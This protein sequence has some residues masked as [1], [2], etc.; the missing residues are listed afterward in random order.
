MAQ[1]SDVQKKYVVAVSGGV[2]SVA[3]LHALVHHQ[4]HELGC[5]RPNAHY[6]LI[7][8]HVDHGMRANSAADA[9]FVQRLAKQY[10]LPFELYQTKLGE[11]ASEAQAREVRYSYL[12]QC[13][14][15]YGTSTI[16]TAHHQ[17][18][19]IE[20]AVINLIR[21]SGWRGLASLNET[22]RI[23]Q[24]KNK[25]CTILRPLLNTA[26][27]ELIEYA[28]QHKLEWHE[29]TTNQNQDYLRNYIRHTLI[30]HAQKRD[31]SFNKK[32]L[33]SIKGV[34][35]VRAEIDTELEYILAKLKRSEK[36]Y[37]VLRY[38]LVMWPPEVASEFI[39]TMLRKLD[40][41]WHPDQKSIAAVL[42]FCKTGLPGKKHIVSGNIQVLAAKRELVFVLRPIGSDMVK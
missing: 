20:T 30:P 13:C 18:D 5:Q 8:A 2:D 16:L 11:D 25:Q 22:T 40:P 35:N 19:V 4:M 7:V 34:K 9:H 6:Q 23:I 27:V 14:K 12:R 24:P 1:M 41:S 17:D 3:L 10:G 37:A 33:Q 32:I 38:Q 42:H 29:D 39:Y 31:A 26:K 15:K 21:G 28:K 36:S